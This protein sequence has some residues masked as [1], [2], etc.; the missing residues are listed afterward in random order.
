MLRK[1]DFLSSLALLALLVLARPALAEG[2][3]DWGH[4][5]LD[6][7]ERV[8]LTRNRTVVSA[9]RATEAAE[10]GVDMAGA[11]PNPTLSLNAAGLNAQRTPDGNHLDAVLRIDQPFERGGKRELRLAVADSLLAASRSDESDTARQQRLAVRQAYYDLKLAEEKARIGDESVVLAGKVLAKAELRLKAG[12]ISPTDVA[13][14]RTDSLKAESDAHQAQVDLQRARL[15]LAQLLAWESVA[16]R[17]HTGDDWPALGEVPRVEPDIAA[18]PDVVAAER[19]LAATEEAVKLAQAQ[20]VRDVTVGVQAE[21]DYQ[22]SRRNLVGVGV[23][24]PLFTG[25]DYRGEIRQALV[26]R[27]SARDALERI[28]ATAAA[29]FEQMSFEA[30]RQSQRASRLRDEA[31]PAARKA[32]AAIQF[33]FTQGAASVLDVIDARRSLFSTEMDTATALADAAK[34]RAAWAAAYNRNDAP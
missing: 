5:R 25:N 3:P 21:R 16:A 29:E 9:R 6:E 19:R 26:A 10:A 24:I 4:L 12:D 11:R 34:A 27:D 15:A 7:A 28:K 22:E 33:A 14:I 13:R 2:T 20:R 23:S 17:L 32:S 1:T 8:A 31:L 30:E 18:R